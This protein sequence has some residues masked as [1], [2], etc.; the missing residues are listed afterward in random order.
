MIR[1]LDPEQDRECLIEAYSW[2]KDY[3]RWYQDL[4]KVSH[5][6]LEQFLKEAPDRADL[7]VF[8]EDRLVALIS[9]IRRAPYVFEGHIWAQRRSQVDNLANAVAWTITRLKEDLQMR[10]GYVWIAKKNAPIKLM[11]IMAGLRFDGG[12]VVDG[13]SHG[14]P[15]VWQRFS[16][17]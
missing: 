5:W 12:V 7:G 3:P 11:C 1:R 17:G 14:K 13:E 15:I 10:F 16:N 2:D 4:E 8:N 6:P 9:I